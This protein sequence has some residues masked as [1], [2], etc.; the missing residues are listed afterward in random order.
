MFHNF[1]CFVTPEYHVCF[2]LAEHV[3]NCRHGLLD[4]SQFLTLRVNNLS[5]FDNIGQV[6]V[7][8]CP[9]FC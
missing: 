1:I 6:T 3:S 5:M 2:F 8:I 9:M 4:K 7:N